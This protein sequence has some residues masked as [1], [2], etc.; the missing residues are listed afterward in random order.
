MRAQVPPGRHPAQ[1]SSQ[2]KQGF[3]EIL[4]DSYLAGDYSGVSDGSRPSQEP[5]GQQEEGAQQ[6]KNAVNRDSHDAKGKKE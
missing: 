6:S 3:F 2:R 1:P 5:H 4:P